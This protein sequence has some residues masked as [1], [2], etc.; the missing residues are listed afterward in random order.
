MYPSSAIVN[1]HT[2]FRTPEIV[3]LIA[4]SALKLG[5]NASPFHLN[6]FYILNAV[7]VSGGALAWIIVVMSPISKG[8]FDMKD[9]KITLKIEHYE[10]HSAL[11]EK[12]IIYE[13]EKKINK[14]GKKDI[15]DSTLEENLLSD[16]ETSSGV[17]CD[18]TRDNYRGRSNSVNFIKSNIVQLQLHAELKSENNKINMKNS[19]KKKEFSRIS[20]LCAALFIIMFCSILQASFFAYVTSSTEGRDIEQ[21]LY[22]DRLFS[23]LLGRPLTRCFRP[24]CLKVKKIRLCCIL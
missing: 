23:D 18:H 10:Y 3:A 22:F 16:D 17:N 15:D 8:Y 24:T 1:L 13:I 19:I 6:I 4:V 20:P 12:K 9:S 21:I 2:G 7:F 11:N 5:K 14:L